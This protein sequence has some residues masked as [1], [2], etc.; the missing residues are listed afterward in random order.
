MKFY[1]NKYEYV[2]ILIANAILFLSI[3]LATH[4]CKE[5]NT[6]YESMFHK[7]NIE[8]PMKVG[9]SRVNGTET[10]NETNEI[11]ADQQKRLSVVSRKHYQTK[12]DLY[13]TFSIYSFFNY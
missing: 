9:Q 4:N 12:N 11:Q 2:I 7:N 13:E 10:D 3:A 8:K 6:M 1:N 5:S